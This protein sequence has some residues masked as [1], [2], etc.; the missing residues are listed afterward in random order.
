[1]PSYREYVAD[2]EFMRDYAAY[3]QRYAVEPRES[4]K[5]L[6][7]LV[8][9]LAGEHAQPLRVLDVGCSTGN[10][11]RHL[12]HT[13]PGLDL[14]GGELAEEVLEECRSDPELAAIAFERMDVLALERT[15][16]FDAVIVNAVLYLFDEAEFARAVASISRALRPGGALLAFDFFHPFEQRLEIHERERT[17]ADGLRLTFRPYSETRVVLERHGFDRIEFRPFEI[18]IDLPRPA[19][20]DEIVSY[21]RRL[22]TG[23][24]LLF[25]GALY[26]PWCHLVARRP[27]L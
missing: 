4:D 3:Q 26:Q 15:A 6:I 12:D 10:L 22:E 5:V 23:G 27:A 1:M 8:R 9:D 18:P 25:R 11:L 17:H 21:T 19:G 24:R 2:D 14:V 13:I 20:D 16:D 7:E